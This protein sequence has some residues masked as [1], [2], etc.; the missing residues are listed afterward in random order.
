MIE[1]GG[2][3]FLLSSSLLSNQLLWGSDK[4]ADSKGLQLS[5]SP[6]HRPHIHTSGIEVMSSTMANVSTEDE[7]FISYT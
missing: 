2:M 1:E 7:G 3:F 4:I 5:N 6:L